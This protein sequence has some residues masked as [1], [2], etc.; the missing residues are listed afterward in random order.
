MVT[1][2]SFIYSVFLY[3][4][5]VSTLSKSLKVPVTCKIRVF[6]DM[7][8]TIEYAKMLEEAGVKMLTVHGRTREQKG[9]LTGL[10]NWEYVKRVR[11]VLYWLFQ[12]IVKLSIVF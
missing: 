7:D 9:P 8:K 12:N 5:S 6:E 4:F 10:A 1:D 2:I 11:F 3:P